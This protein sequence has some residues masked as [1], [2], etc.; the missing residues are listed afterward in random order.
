MN[1]LH[2][3]QPEVPD[4]VK[5]FASYWWGEGH[6]KDKY[7]LRYLKTRKRVEYCTA[8]LNNWMGIGW[9]LSGG[10]E[11]SC[12]AWIIGHTIKIPFQPHFIEVV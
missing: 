1:N 7:P 10:N 11:K 4:W 8:G 12:K 5:E 3:I 9:G 2:S 6:T